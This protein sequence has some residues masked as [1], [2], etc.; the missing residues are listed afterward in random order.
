VHIVQS[1]REFPGAVEAVCAPEA[2][3]EALGQ[4]ADL[5]VRLYLAHAARQPLVFLHAVTAPAALAL[6]FPHVPPD[7]QRAALAH[8]WQVTA[9]LVAS[10]SDGE[11]VA[12]LDADPPAVTERE[13]VAR[14]IATGDV[15]AIKLTEACTRRFR[16]SGKPAYLA[17]AAD[18]CARVERAS[19]WTDE[20]R[21]AA[22]MRFD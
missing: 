13:L 11:P 15:H 3:A 14:A 22:G 2:N 16:E 4:L 17:A 20:Q 7:A 10:Y 6:L 19:A 12:P 8:L 9:A 18:W 1:A 5:G 21:T